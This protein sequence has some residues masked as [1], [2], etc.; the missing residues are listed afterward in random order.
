MLALDF[1]ENT[2]TVTVTAEDGTTQDY[3]L[4]ITRALP[5]LRWEAN[6]YKAIAEDS[7]DVELVVLLEPASDGVVEVDYATSPRSGSVAGEDYVHTSGTLR[8]EP[9]D[10]EKTVTVTIL[11]DT[12]Y[13]PNGAGDLQVTLS[14]LSGTAE[15]GQHGPTIL[16]LMGLADLSDPENDEP[17]TASM[18]D[19]S[20]DEDA[21]A[22]TFVLK[23]EPSGRGGG[24]LSG[25]LLRNRRHG[26]SLGGLRTIPRIRQRGN[27]IVAEAI[28][29]EFRGDH[30]RRR[31][32]RGGRNHHA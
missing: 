32:R 29:R 13:E 10:T 7:G 11:D 9:G 24:H 18:E 26:N 19:V 15:Y 30:P 5:V 22:M 28:H 12:I 1:G 2:V 25:E 23:P 4:V 3:T 21:G 16:M 6:Q 20:V 8:F 31:H 14:N 17:P 27:R